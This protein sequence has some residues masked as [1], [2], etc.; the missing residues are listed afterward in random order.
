MKVQILLTKNR[1]LGKVLQKSRPER[2]IFSRINTPFLIISSLLDEFELSNLSRFKGKTFLDIQGYVRNGSN[3]GKKRYWRPNK[4]IFTTIFC[5][6]GTREELNYIPTSYIKKQKK[7]I[8]L[9]TNSKY[10]CEVFAF[11]KRSVFRPSKVINGENTIG[12]GDTFFAYFVSRFAKT[13]DAFDAVKYA[14]NRTSSFLSS[15]NSHHHNQLF[16]EEIGCS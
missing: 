5:L 3:F 11:G 7:K 13:D 8:L 1:E 4:E 14:M 2:I 12:A 9:T 6:K 16:R 15:Q 10:G